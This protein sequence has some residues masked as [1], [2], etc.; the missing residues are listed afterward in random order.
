MCLFHITDCGSDV[1][2]VSQLVN[3]FNF[4][5]LAHII[6]LIV[7]KFILQAN[8]FDSADDETES[9]SGD[10]SEDEVEPRFCSAVGSVKE[11][12]AKITRTPKLIDQLHQAHSILQEP[13]LSLITP[14]TTR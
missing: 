6:N 9:V 13:E 5:C 3:A 10:D 12:V 4:P 14:N 7:Q 2:N 8:A 11:I 1:R